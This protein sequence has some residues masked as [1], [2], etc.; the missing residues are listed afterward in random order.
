MGKKTAVTDIL[1][2][3]VQIFVNFRGLQ[4]NFYTYNYNNIQII[5][6]KIWQVLDAM[7]VC[8]SKKLVP[9]EHLH[10]TAT[11]VCREIHKIIH[12]YC[13]F[14]HMEIPREMGNSSTTAFDK[15]TVCPV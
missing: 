12:T 5:L 11:P 10:F 6:Q 13:C 8:C 4:I 2:L 3:S 7:F 15:G 9:P 14:Q 1:S